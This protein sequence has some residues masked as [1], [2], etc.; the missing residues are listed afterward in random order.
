[1]TT[2]ERLNLWQYTELTR[3]GK[4]SYLVRNNLSGRLMV[5][6][7]CSGESFSVYERLSKIKNPYLMKI[8][9]AVV[10]DG[11]CVSLCK[12]IDGVT[13]EKAVNERGVYSEAE[14][15]NI[16]AQLC[17]GLIKLHS[18][19][20]IHRDINPSNVMLDRNGIVKIIDYDIVRTVK[21]DKSSDTQI[22]GTPGY[23]APEQFGFT[24]TDARADIYSCGVLM[25]FLLTGEIP[26][27]RLYAG[28]L[29]N[30]ILKCTEMDAENR[31]RSMYE[32]QQIVL[33]N[34]VIY[35]PD[36]KTPKT[37]I[38]YRKLPGFRSGRIF[39]KVLTVALMVFYFI[40]LSAYVNYTVQLFDRIP[41]PRRHTVTGI[42]L[43]VLASLIPYC[44]IGDIGRISR[45]ISPKNPLRA[46]FWM[47]VI[48]AVS[49]AAG[50][51][52][53]LNF[54]MI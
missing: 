46:R 49:L 6:C 3:L 51:I 1:M 16:T 18:M 34:K 41:Y 48:G 43:F 13:L 27:D 12:F 21:N 42:S 53:F 11:K 26:K 5:K 14:V 50:V 17:D 54:P 19:G 24:Q 28:N 44:L 2:D 52:L 29:T 35:N 4:N 40:M 38:D 8:F 47:R 39:P 9:D 10:E 37:Y 45:R 30:V 33:G 20:I 25:N 15:R 36:K 31:F 7:V 32:F 22:L 23:A